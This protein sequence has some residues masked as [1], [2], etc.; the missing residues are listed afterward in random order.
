MQ[1]VWRI[2]DLECM[3]FKFYLKLSLVFDIFKNE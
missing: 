1:L 2:F 3:I